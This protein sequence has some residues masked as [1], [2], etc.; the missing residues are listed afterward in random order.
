MTPPRNGGSQAQVAQ[1][2]S[3]LPNGALLRLALSLARHGLAQLSTWLPLRIVLAWLV[4]RSLALGVALAA[5]EQASNP[6][7]PLDAHGLVG[8]ATRVLWMWDGGWYHRI[9]TVGYAHA[10]GTASS[11]V[12]FFPLY[13]LT[14]KGLSA[15]LHLPDVVTGPLLSTLC[16]LAAGA[17]LYR[18]V[19]TQLD[20]ERAYWAV[21]FL[22]FAPSSIHLGAYYTESFFLSLSLAC[23]LC[24]IERRWWG[25][26]VF[27]ALATATRPT[28]ILLSLAVLLNY[29]QAHAWK[30]TSLRRIL[31][32]HLAI[33]ASAL[34]ALT[35]AA[36]LEVKFGSAAVYLQAQQTE[37]PRRFRVGNFF[38]MIFDVETL[39]SYSMETLLQGFLPTMLALTGAV[40]LLHRRRFGD[41]LLVCGSLFLSIGGGTFE[42][43]QRYLLSLFPLYGLLA[44][45]PSPA[46]RALVLATSAV[47]MGYWSALFGGQWHFT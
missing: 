27:G 8:R 19:Q 26:A 45:I 9:A 24:G 32:P 13:P 2:E 30:G 7:N 14:V 15:L 1:I 41:A 18:L 17:L 6:S 39:T 42:G 16:A 20:Q 36:Y 47:V 37:W 33:G 35:Y 40:W 38:R 23:Y 34:G 5:T 44:S 43:T 12:A 46:A 25:V 28:G 22:F 11:A 10:D 29:W 31:W 4:S 21:L 3:G